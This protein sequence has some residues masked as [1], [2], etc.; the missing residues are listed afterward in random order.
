MKIL[1]SIDSFKGSLSSME[2]GNAAAEGFAKALP[3]AQTA[4]RPLADGGEGTVEA[5]VNGMGGSLRT[6]AVCDPLGRQVQA[7]YGIMPDKTAIIE[8][9][10]ASGLTLLKPEER[11]P[12]K[13]TTFGTGMM[14]KD[15][16]DL[17]C[18]KFIIGIGGSATNDG[19]I[20]CLQALGYNMLDAEGR[21]VPFGAQGCAELFR[22]DASFADPHLKECEFF[23]ACDV[24]NPL[25]GDD[26]CSM[27]FS[28]QKGADTETAMRMDIFMK[29]YAHM[30][31]EINPEADPDAPGS[32]AAGGLG[33]ALV[34]YLNAKLC[35]GADLIIGAV[36]TE[37]LISGADIIVTGEGC[38]DEQTV[39]GKAPITLA[40]LAKKY[41]KPV[42][43]FSG[44]AGKNAELCN[45]NGIDAFFP[46]LRDLMT[47]DEAMDKKNA[48]ENLTAA[49]YQV[50]CLLKAAGRFR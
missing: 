30:T 50:G 44:I 45:S 8:M 24:K 1:I 18:R 41:H 23:V 31:K 46:V 43:A 16:M 2:A 37:K 19:G 48:A 20:G 11:D 26:G 29:K 38:I 28:H 6:I 14:I 25:Y 9:A 27:V 47:P 3:G 12:M 33:F 7:S 40:R 21:Q 42:I 13:T 34:S 10:A 32:G 15:A 39:M 35:P 17:G 22:I 49:A 4:V 36:G 5:L